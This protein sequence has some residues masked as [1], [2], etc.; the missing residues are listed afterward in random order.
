MDKLIE[1]VRETKAIA[2]DS[3]SAHDITI[4]GK[5]DF[6]TKVDIGVQ[7]FLMP[8]LREMYPDVQF[9]SEEKDNSGIDM[10][11]R[12]WVLD[13]ID[14]TTNL[15]HDY[16]MS[17]V[18]L[19]MLEN[20]VPVCG[21]VYNPFTNELYSARSGEGAFLNGSS[22][23]VSGAARLSESLISVGTSPYYKE[24]ADENFDIIKR[25]FIASEDVRRCGSAAMDLCYIACGRV[26]GYFEKRLKP[27][28]YAAGIA[29]LREA[30]GAVTALDGGEPSYSSPSDIAA[31]NGSIH[32][33]L[34]SLIMAQ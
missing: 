16:R 26:D 1:L 8:R 4:K 32:S 13:P 5:A 24:L 31:S 30:G 23:R 10:S 25:L 34:L 12:V 17:A 14:G 21:V 28:D 20:G 6:V 15:I 29:I 22:I 19:G 9:M 2:L 11:G 7:E 3:G 33:E 18:S 27:W